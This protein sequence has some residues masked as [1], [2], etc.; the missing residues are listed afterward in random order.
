MIIPLG[1]LSE[2]SYGRWSE[3]GSTCVPLEL[4]LFLL[5]LGHGFVFR[6][7]PD[8][9]LMVFCRPGFRV[10]SCDTCSTFPDNKVHSGS[11]AAQL[12]A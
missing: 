5:T 3:L 8:G 4:C 10:Q 9:W 6:F 1:S 11:Q 7:L 12:Q 2:P